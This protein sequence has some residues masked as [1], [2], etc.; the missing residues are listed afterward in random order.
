MITKKKIVLD[1]LDDGTA[2]LMYPSF[3]T[4]YPLF[5]TFYNSFFQS[6]I[7]TPNETTFID[8]EIT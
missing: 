2:C 4:A 5:M 3:T 6:S 8:L 1:C 7:Y